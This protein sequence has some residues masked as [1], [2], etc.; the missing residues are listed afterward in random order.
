MDDVDR[1]NRL[2]RALGWAWWVAV[3]LALVPFPLYR[4]GWTGVGFGCSVA[5][6]AL[7]AFVLGTRFMEK[8][9]SAALLMPLSRLP[10]TRPVAPSSPPSPP[11]SQRPG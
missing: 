6:L 11:E 2:R 9:L 1:L 5:A 4:L 10:Q 8:A 7:G 3:A